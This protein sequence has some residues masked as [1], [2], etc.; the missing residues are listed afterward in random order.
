M[1]IVQR[2]HPLLFQFLILH[3]TVQFLLHEVD[4]GM[5]EIG[6][7][8][9]RIVPLNLVCNNLDLP[10]GTRRYGGDYRIFLV[11]KVTRRR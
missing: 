5:F 3:P 2:Q 10:P 4:I 11:D 6:R 8:R 9:L 7:I 1:Y